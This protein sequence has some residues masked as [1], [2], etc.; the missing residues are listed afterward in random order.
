MRRSP[1]R[2]FWGVADQGLSSLGNFLLSVIIA[3]QVSAV[4]FGAF[5]AAFTAYLVVN[6]ISRAVSSETYTVVFGTRDDEHARAG[7]AASVG[8][9]LVCG[10]IAATLV[11]L[12]GVLVPAPLSG[13]LLAFAVALPGLVVQDAWRFL[14]F[15]R[16]EPRAAAQNDALW[17][18]VAVALIA[19]LVIVGSVSVG[20]YVLAWGT[21]AWA[22]SAYGIWQSRTTPRPSMFRRWLREHAGLTWRYAIDFASAH[23]AQLASVWLL[24]VFG[25]L[26]ALGAYRGALVLVGPLNVLFSGVV[27]LAVPE[28]VAMRERGPDRIPRASLLLGGVLMTIGLLWGFALSLM[29]DALGTAALGRTWETAQAALV[30]VALWVA[31]TGI[32]AGPLVGLRGLA[33]AGRT[34]RSTVPI[35]PLVLVGGAVGGAYGGAVGASL[36]WAACGLL[37]AALAWMNLGEAVKERRTPASPGVQLPHLSTDV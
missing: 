8:T 11:A 13:V 27:M 14:F 24:G 36:W 7:A 18:G 19:G 12:V 2:L 16:G 17:T 9:A 23:G 5:G 33:A 21:G 29:P 4:D 15:A 1:H 26:A 6:G 30:P 34:L 35:A 20:H 22:A 31:T 32:Q 25:G 3:R 10:L 28:M 37:G